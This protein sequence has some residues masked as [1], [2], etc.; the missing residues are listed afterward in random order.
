MQMAL[1]RARF[2]MV[3]DIEVIV[4]R[5]TMESNGYAAAANSIAQDPDNETYIFR[6][7]DRLT[8]RNLLNIQGELLAL[9]HELDVLD[10]AAALSSEPGL[11]VAMRSW[12]AMHTKIPDDDGGDN[13]EKEKR[14][15]IAAQLEVKLKKY[16]KFPGS[17][18]CLFRLAT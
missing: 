14:V 16:R 4:S 6:R 15:R 3:Y 7:F 17:D 11:H 1:V 13:T 8:A 12:A 18:L 2:V 10:K 9:Q 5:I